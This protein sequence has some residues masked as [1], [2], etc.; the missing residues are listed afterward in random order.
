MSIWK[1]KHY[2]KTYQNDKSL[3]IQLCWYYTNALVFN[4]ALIP[5]N[6]IKIFLLKLY[7]TRIGE[8][9]V[10]KPRVSIKYPWKLEISD[11]VWIGEGVWIDNLD[12]VEIGKDSVISQGATLITGNHDY[13]SLGFDLFTKPIVIE[14]NVW[15][16]AKTTLLP[17]TRIK[18]GTITR[19]GEVLKN[20]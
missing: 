18:S 15:V 20:E 1:L 8:G 19:P 5:F 16:T 4:S 7:G 10:I 3:L 6:G 11:F 14:S 13:K 12:L 17:G 2:R 9:V